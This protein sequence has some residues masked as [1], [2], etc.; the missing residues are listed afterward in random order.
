MTINVN[1]MKINL[2]DYDAVTKDIIAVCVK[3]PH[4]T[5]RG[6]KINLNSVRMSQAADILENLQSGLCDTYVVSDCGIMSFIMQVKK[7]DYLSNYFNIDMFSIQ[8]IVTSTI[9]HRLNLFYANAVL[10]LLF[11]TIRE[12]NTNGLYSLSLPAENIALNEVFMDFGF[13]YREGFV[14]MVSKT[15]G[16]VE[17]LKNISPN[18]HGFYVDSCVE[19]DIADI[20]SWY[21]SSTFPSRFV[22]EPGISTKKATLLYAHRFREVLNNPKI[23]EVICIRNEN[24]EPVGAIIYAI[25]QRL[26]SEHNIMTNLLSGMGMI[27]HPDYRKIGLGSTLVTHRQAL[28][29]KN[30]AEWVSLGA[31]IN[32]RKMIRCLE[33]LGFL[34]GCVDI[35]LA[36]WYS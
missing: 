26:S 24:K 15:E 28:Y 21:K 35:S 30:G 10:P 7:I 18:L 27:I 33:E 5:Y 19:N 3:N 34:Y 31:N 32:N 11:E 6:T 17:K 36:R 8:N 16:F 9:D 2:Y 22:T 29:E 13:S 4:P 20:E 12:L 23:G 14:S 1:A 25:N